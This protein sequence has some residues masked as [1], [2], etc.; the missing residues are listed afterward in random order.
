MTPLKANL[1]IVHYLDGRILRGTTLDFFPTK[2]LFHLTG[3]RGEVVEIKIGELKAVFFVKHLSGEENYKERKGFFAD[4]NRGKKIM[5]EFL[6]TEVIFGYTLTF[7]PKKLGFF[8]TPGDHQSNNEK[9]FVVHS[10]TKRIKIHSGNI[11][12]PG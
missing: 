7:S 6:D 5:V 4:D 3:V 12:A 10:S 11:V 1:I 8:M 2:P 9:I